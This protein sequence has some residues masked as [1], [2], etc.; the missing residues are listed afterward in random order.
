MALPLDTI[1][2]SCMYLM[3]KEKK[4]LLHTGSNAGQ[5][6]FAPTFKKIKEL[7]PSLDI[8]YIDSA[9][10]FPGSPESFRQKFDGRSGTMY[11]LKMFMTAMASKEENN[12][13]FSIHYK[14]GM[15]HFLQELVSWVTDWKVGI[16]EDLYEWNYRELLDYR[17]K[18]VKID[19]LDCRY[20]NNTIQSNTRIFFF[21]DEYSDFDHVQ[22]TNADHVRLHVIYDYHSGLERVREPRCCSSVVYQKCRAFNN[23]PDEEQDLNYYVLYPSHPTTSQIRTIIKQLKPDKIFGLSRAPGVN[24]TELKDDFQKLTDA[25][26]R[27]SDFGEWILNFS[28]CVEFMTEFFNWLCSLFIYWAWLY[29]TILKPLKSKNL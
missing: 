23:D 25:F 24:Y 4:F 8:L 13:F 27:T 26:L 22:S 11:R 1:P 14:V 20:L 9:L 21:T 17:D 12:Y 29:L 19:H 6:D 28:L 2:G 7:A 5:E 16:T 3:S 15:E 10:Y 18:V